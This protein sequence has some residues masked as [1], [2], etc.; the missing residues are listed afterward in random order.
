MSVRSFKKPLTVFTLTMLITGSSDSIRNFPTTALFGS[1]LIFFLLLAGI[2]FL[3]PTALISAQLASALPQKSGIYH[4]V[5]L[6]FGKKSA[7][8][9]I[10]L[11][12]INTMVWF[13]T[14]LSFIGGTMA[15]LINPSLAH[16]KT[17]L[18]ATILSIFW[19]MTLFNLKGIR[20]S[21]RFA[22][23][24]AI[25]GMLIPITLIIALAATWLLSGHA[26]QIHLT[27]STLF[28]KLG[29][30]ETWISLT[31]IMTAFLGMELATVHINQADR[32]QTT[33]L[34]LY[35]YPSLLLSSP[36][37]S[38]HSVLP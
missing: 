10:W 1:T 19:I 32:P 21:A 35:F 13:P 38:A 5:K 24:C 12:W 29:H 22:T 3:I 18:V 27:T 14:I 20:Y 36:C 11:Q 15:Y 17:Y 37:C 33:S 8:M 31:A 25:F 2:F 9:A 16:N 4:W 6:A 7:C 23:I 30:S 28:P 34:G 26:A